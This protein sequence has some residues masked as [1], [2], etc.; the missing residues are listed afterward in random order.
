MKN[1]KYLIGEGRIIKTD[2]KTGK[3]IVIGKTLP[4][5]YEPHS[6]IESVGKS[7]TDKNKEKR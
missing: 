3:E 1:K 2:P 7:E 5:P 4:G 6:C